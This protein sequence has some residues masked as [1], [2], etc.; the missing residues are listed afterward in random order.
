M[1][2]EI[3]AEAG[4]ILSWTKLNRRHVGSVA[5]YFTQTTITYNLVKWTIDKF[6][7]CVSG[8][9]EQN[10]SLVFKTPLHGMDKGK[11]KTNWLTKGNYN[12]ANE[13]WV[14]VQEDGSSPCF[15]DKKETK[16]QWKCAQ[17]TVCFF[18]ACMQK[19][20]QFWIHVLPKHNL[21]CVNVWSC[22]F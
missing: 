2:W 3:W 18:L 21:K 13:G 5:F 9:T 14:L 20:A 17:H 11:L 7:G 4:N 1:I 6:C 19:W 16:K 12:M 15:F 10:G 8:G 22:T